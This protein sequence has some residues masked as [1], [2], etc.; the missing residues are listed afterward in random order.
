MFDGLKFDSAAEEKKVVA[1]LKDTFLTQKIEKA[2]IGVSGGVD[3]ATNLTLLSKSIPRE[4]IIALYLP[5]LN[6]VDK[7]I[8]E[9]ESYLGMRI[10]TVSIKKTTDELIARL[11]IPEKEIVRRGNIMARV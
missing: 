8:T 11:G 5:Y 6:E 3:S 2:V 10:T 1:F 9:L 4:D 7:S